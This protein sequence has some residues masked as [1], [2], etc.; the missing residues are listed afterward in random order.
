MGQLH[1]LN[2]GIGRAMN[3]LT[4]T[5]EMIIGGMGVRARN[6]SAIL[7][8]TSSEAKAKA[9]VAAAKALRDASSKIVLANRKDMERGAANG[10]TSAMLD[11]LRLDETRIAGIA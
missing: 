3:D 8:R 5:P 1:F 4:Q 10:L 2:A 6:A 11:R 9:L 7:A